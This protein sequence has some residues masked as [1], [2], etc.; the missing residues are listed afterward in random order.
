LAIFFPARVYKLWPLP[1]CPLA[2]RSTSAAAPRPGGSALPVSTGRRPGAD[3]P[4]TLIQHQESENAMTQRNSMT[5]RNGRL[6]AL[7]GALA[8]GLV[9]FIGSGAAGW[10]L[11]S[12]AGGTPAAKPP[13][14]EVVDAKEAGRR[15]TAWFYAGGGELDK[16]WELFSPSMR[17]GM[18]DLAALRAFRERGMSDF[19]SETSVLDERV[20][21]TGDDQVYT[22]LAKF[23]GT[24]LIVEVT[25][26]IGRDGSIVG[27]YVRPQR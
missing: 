8:V 1:T 12:G 18:G 24:P 7:I 17:K 13:A 9:S 15:Y 11:Q 4:H 5:Q 3:N 2:A 23:S 16:I 25:W 6:A 20:R 19:G 27:F 21:T 22:R 14:G 26:E 10:S